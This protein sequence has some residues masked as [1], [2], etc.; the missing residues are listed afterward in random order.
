MSPGQN[1]PDTGTKCPLLGFI[2]NLCVVLSQLKYI[3]FLRRHE[4][5]DYVCTAIFRGTFC[6]GDILSLGHFVQGA[7]CPGFAVV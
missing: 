2:T 7:L 5:K 6:P 1:A 3:P 4:Q